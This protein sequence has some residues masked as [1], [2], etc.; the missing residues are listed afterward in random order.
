MDYKIKEGTLWVH[1]QPTGD[2]IPYGWEENRQAWVPCDAAYNVDDYV[3]TTREHEEAL[4]YFE[5]E[6]YRLINDGHA[7]GKIE[8][9]SR[10]GG[11]VF[12]FSTSWEGDK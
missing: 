10:L 4:A 1:V 5:N 11:F 2:S 9:P 3:R 12:S 6:L 7:G 8:L